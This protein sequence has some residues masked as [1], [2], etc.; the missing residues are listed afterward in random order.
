MK[1]SVIHNRK[2]DSQL[3]MARKS[4][5]LARKHRIKVSNHGRHVA[6][7]LGNDVDALEARARRFADV[8]RLYHAD[9]EVIHAT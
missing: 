2:L 8:V 4:Q 9:F 6:T 7:L 3:G 5:R 1:D